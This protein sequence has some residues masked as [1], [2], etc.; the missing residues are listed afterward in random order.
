MLTYSPF[1]A[2]KPL[3]GVFA[4]RSLSTTIDPSKPAFAQMVL[5][6]ILQASRIILIPTFWSKLAPYRFLRRREA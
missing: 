4:S 6:G 5:V 2:L 1:A 3:V